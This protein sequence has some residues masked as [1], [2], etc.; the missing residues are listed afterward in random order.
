MTSFCQKTSHR[1]L[2]GKPQSLKPIYSCWINL[3][4]PK[5]RD[6]IIIEPILIALAIFSDFV[7]SLLF[8]RHDIEDARIIR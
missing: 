2:K 5:V 6:L 8:E 1:V 7:F 4:D 3:N